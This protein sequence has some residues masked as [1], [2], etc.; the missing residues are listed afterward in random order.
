MAKQTTKKRRLQKK[1]RRRQIE[2]EKEME[3]QK[4]RL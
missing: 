3:E 1:L 2:V 4:E